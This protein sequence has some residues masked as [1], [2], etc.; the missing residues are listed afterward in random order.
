MIAALILS[1][2]SI[3]AWAFGSDLLWLVLGSFVM[4]AGVQGAF[5][6][7]LPTSMSYRP[8]PCA[9]SFPDSSINSAFLSPPRRC[10]LS[11]SCE[12]VLA[13]PGP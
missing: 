6:V 10:H 1:L 4:Q 13:I 8:T 3:P 12:I 9:V 2:L 7:F 5:G 11:T